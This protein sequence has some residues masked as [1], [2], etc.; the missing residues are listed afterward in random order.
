MFGMFK[1]CFVFLRFSV[2]L[3][4]GSIFSET[5]KGMGRVCLLLSLTLLTILSKVIRTYDIEITEN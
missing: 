1:I 4:I 2:A 3:N 5:I